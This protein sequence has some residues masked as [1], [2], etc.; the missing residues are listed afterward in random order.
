MTVK[1]VSPEMM[2]IAKRRIVNGISLKN[3]TGAQRAACSRCNASITVIG[4]I[5]RFVCCGV[6]QP[7]A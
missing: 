7:L 5:D 2:A 6:E 1:R 4:A 3:A